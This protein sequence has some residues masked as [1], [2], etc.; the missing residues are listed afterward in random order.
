LNVSFVVCF[1]H[2][3]IWGLYANA[4]SEDSLKE[5]KDTIKKKLG[6]APDAV[7][8]LSQVR[9]DSTVDLEDGR[10][11]ISVFRRRLINRLLR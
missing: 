1:L 2:D 7:V 8:N 9:G 4:C 3:P 10:S 5:L 6:L 11:R